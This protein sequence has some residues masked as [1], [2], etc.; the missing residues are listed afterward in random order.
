MVSEPVVKAMMEI[1]ALSFVVP[2]AFV[3]I[4]KMR[5]RKS[6]I[7]SLTGVLVFLTF[8]IILKSVPNLLF[9]SVD[10]PVSRFIN[11]SIWAYA[12]YCGLAAGIFEEAG[13]YVAFKLFLKN[14]DYRESSVA[15]GLGHG[16]IE[17]IVVLGFAMLQNF[18][19]AQIIN[20]GQME[21]MISTFPDESAKAVFMDLQQAIINMTVQDC[22]WAGVERLSALALQVSLSV[23]V[24]QAARIQNKKH[25]LAIAILL[26]A[27]IDVFAAFS[28]QGRLPVA[29]IEIV[30]IIYALIVSVF[31][32]KI[33]TSLPHDDRKSAESRQNWSFA[34]KKLEKDSSSGNGSTGDGNG[35]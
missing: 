21:E 6:I 11:G 5:F 29:V 34:S 13:R 23:L 20:A 28:Q 7:P 9:L 17:C 35:N 30:I 19:Y 27:L 1:A 10:S 2:F 8:G 33:Y 15:Y 25:L 14:H 16:G 3:L 4:W 32:Y 18:T 26:H 22:I 24:Y 31:A 12:I